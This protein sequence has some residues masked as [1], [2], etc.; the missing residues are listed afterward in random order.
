MLRF[1]LSVWLRQQGVECLESLN[2]DDFRKA[3]VG[4]GR[5]TEVV[6]RVEHGRGLLK[7]GTVT[8]EHA[9]R[10]RQGERGKPMEPEFVGAAGT[11]DVKAGDRGDVRL[12]RARARRDRRAYARTAFRCAICRRNVVT[13]A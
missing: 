12:G 9:A 2:G 13:K 5:F 6:E 3:G 8:A 11:R 4:F 7:G 10:R 1:V